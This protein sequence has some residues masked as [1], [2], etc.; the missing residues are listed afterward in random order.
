MWDTSSDS[1]VCM[2]ARDCHGSAK[3]STANAAHAL[4][5]HHPTGNS[6]TAFTHQKSTGMRK[7]KKKR[8]KTRFS[9]PITAG[10]VV[11]S[12]KESGAK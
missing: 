4:R 10:T 9:D 11:T 2:V 7:A 12:T 1:K 6:P 3:A 5:R 8:P